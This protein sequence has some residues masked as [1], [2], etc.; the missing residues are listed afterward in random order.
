MLVAFRG[1]DG[2][3]V[4][5]ESGTARP[6]FIAYSRS[7]SAADIDAAVGKMFNEG[8][9]ES[10]LVMFQ[11]TWYR[12]RDL[13]EDYFSRHTP[14]QAESWLQLARIRKASE[15]EAARQALLR[16]NALQRIVHQEFSDSSMKKLAEELGMDGLPQQIS[17]EMMKTLGLGE[18]S[19]PG[20][21]E[22]TVCENEPAAIWLGDRDGE[23]S[24]LL[25]TPIRRRGIHPERTLRIET[26]KMD[27]GSWSRSVQTQGDLTHS[28]DAVHTHPLSD[29]QE[30]QVISEVVQDGRAYRLTLCRSSPPGVQQAASAMSSDAI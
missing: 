26:L 1:D 22:V 19:E 10:A 16:A 6:M 5:G 2:H 15:P 30:V 21:I 13:L 27:E 28:G 24:W 9:D 12:H 18:L 8:A 23:Q 20:E 3:W 14:T 29:R 25:L 11:N 7:M 17:H 4:A